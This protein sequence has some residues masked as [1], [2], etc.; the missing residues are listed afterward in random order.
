MV[1]LSEQVLDRYPG[2]NLRG[3]GISSPGQLFVATLAWGK[4]ESGL[5]DEAKAVLA[6]VRGDGFATMPTHYLRIAMLSFLSR[7]SAIVEALD[8]AED[9]YGLLLPHRNEMAMAQ[10]GWIGPVTHDLGLLAT[11]PGRYDEAEQH[12]ADAERFQEHA[13]TPASLVHTRLAWARMLLRRGRSDDPSRAGILLEAA[14]AGARQV[15]IP[16]IEAQIDQLLSEF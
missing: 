12:F 2:A 6:D 10:G 4:A 13:S 8:A 5:R 9:L 14:K 11:V 16:L 7:A 1:A 3:V 15:N